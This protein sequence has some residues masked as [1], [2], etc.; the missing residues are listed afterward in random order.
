MLERYGHGGD[1]L[2][3]AELF[4]HSP[5]L[6]L[7]YSSNM[8]PMGPPACVQQI[9]SER[10]TEVVRY[11]DPAARVLR[12]KIAAH[13]RIPEESILVG[14]GAAELID[15]VVRITQPATVAVTAPSFVEY[16]DNALRVGATLHY[17]PLNV[18]HSF[19]VQAEDL[20]HALDKADLTMLGHPNNPT[21][22]LIP[23]VMLDMLQTAKGTVLLDEAF[24]DFLE[25]E[26]QVSMIQ[27]AP[28]MK[29]LIVI[30]SMTKFF[31]IPG[32]RLGFVVA[33]PDII[34]QMRNLQVQWS[35]NHFSQLIGAAALD[36]TQYIANTKKWVSTERQWFFEQLSSIGF[37]VIQSAV[38]YLLVRLPQQVPFR[39]PEMQKKLGEM[40]ILIRDASRFPGLDERY[41]RLAVRLRKDNETIVRA[42]EYITQP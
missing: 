9:F 26:E 6:F 39:V 32:I 16:S 7:D 5:D 42:L 25:N 31:A 36:D 19:D 33:H 4:G 2:T 18:E 35:V 17:I 20:S 1:L 15:L 30:R 22:R 40:K 23:D 21:G 8:N 37:N 13:Y 24:I 11:P 34:L 14:N 28:S 41:F 12:A 27:R 29:K 38:N 3:A 10:W